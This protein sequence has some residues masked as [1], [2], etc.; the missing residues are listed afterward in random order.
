M[1]KFTLQDGTEI[2][3]FTPDEVKAT[4]EKETG[5]LKAKV[6]EL[7]GESKSAKQK[8]RELE[9]AQQRAEEERQ[10]EKG[11]FKTLYERELK[12]KQE[13]AEKYNEFQSKVQRQEISLEATKIAGQLAK[14]TARA[15][16]LAEKVAQ[17]AKHTDNGVRFE[18][19]GVEVDHDK[20][21]AHLVE[22]YPF[23]VD[24]SG[25][26]GGGAPSGSHGGR[27]V[28]KGDMGGDREARK[29]AIAARFKLPQ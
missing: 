27:A 12:A 16:L 24:A 14:D 13:L 1:A 5:G 17:L 23:L 21:V 2:E 22:K 19:G 29:A 11:E 6:D 26:N 9:E 7:L 15:E 10:R 3:A 20:V 18:I 28:T 8:A 25:A 4:I